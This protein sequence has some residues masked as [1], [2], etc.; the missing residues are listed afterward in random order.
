MMAQ[1]AQP[2]HSFVFLATMGQLLLRISWPCSK[3]TTF[4]PGIQFGK[5]IAGVDAGDAAADDSDVPYHFVVHF[6][7]SINSQN[8]YNIPHFHKRKKTVPNQKAL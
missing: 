6:D 1:E 8:R 2:M 7:T 3:S 5:L 4:S